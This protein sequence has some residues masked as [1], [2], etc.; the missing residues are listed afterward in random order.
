M[1]LTLDELAS[2]RGGYSDAD[3]GRCGPGSHLKFLGDVRTSEC[4]A[5]DGAVR[6]A[7][8]NGS[9]QVGAQLRALPLLPAAVGSYF[10][11]RFTGK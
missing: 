9:S 3:F 2:V 4:A 7:L 11:A 8:A 1:D 5:H 6:G 10:R